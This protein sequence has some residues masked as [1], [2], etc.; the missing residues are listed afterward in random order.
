VIGLVVILPLIGSGPLWP[1]AV[2]STAQVCR[3][4]W[5]HNILFVNNFQSPTKLVSLTKE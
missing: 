3:K 2:E 4:N 1:Q 5:L